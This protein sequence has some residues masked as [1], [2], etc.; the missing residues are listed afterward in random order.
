MRLLSACFFLFASAAHGQGAA[1]DGRWANPDASVII[2]I[3]SC[4]EVRC[5]TVAWA[6]DKAKADA[7]KGTDRLVGSDLLTGLKEKK[8]GHWE[9]RLFIPDQNMRARAKIE[10][11]GER[12]LKVSGCVFR[13]LCRTQ[14]WNRVDGPLP[15]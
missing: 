3:A 14:Y 11:I 15:D 8:P 9:G 12:Q 4:G 1:I 10:P 7:R 2:D 6:S 13:I 5:G